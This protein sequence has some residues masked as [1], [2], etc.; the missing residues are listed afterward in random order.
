MLSMQLNRQM[1]VTFSFNHFDINC[2]LHKSLF[3][4][5]TALGQ[6]QNTEEADLTA[7]GAGVGGALG[8][9][10]LVIIIL[11]V[12]LYQRAQSR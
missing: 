7:I 10:V 4:T 8:F 5:G 12:I 2:I 11:S 1:K 3:T 6:V 9:L